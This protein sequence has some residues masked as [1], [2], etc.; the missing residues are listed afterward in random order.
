MQWI[1]IGFVA[2]AGATWMLLLAH[3]QE[4][5]GMQ[6]VV[7]LLLSIAIPLTFIFGLGTLY[8]FLVNGVGGR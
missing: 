3:P 7:T 4:E 8:F 6:M 2:S 5:K 1:S